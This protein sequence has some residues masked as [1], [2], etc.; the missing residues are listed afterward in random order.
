MLKMTDFIIPNWPAPA[1]VHAL[2]TTRH[3]VISLP[4]YDSLNLG[5]HV[6]DNPL[7]VAHN[8]QLL[9]QFVPSEP[10]WLNQVH[11][12]TVVDAANTD[13]VPDKT[14]YRV[15]DHDGRLPANTIVR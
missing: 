2:Q 4:P 1:N 6:Q 5:S 14:K 7:H 13:C 11:G 12:T 9:S 3:G 10:V 15:R 8:R